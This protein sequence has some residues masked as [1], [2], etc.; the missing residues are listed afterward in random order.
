LCDNRFEWNQIAQEVDLVGSRR[1][2]I[3][4]PQRAQIALQC[5]ATKGKRD[6]TRKHLSTFQMI[7]LPCPDYLLRQPNVKLTMPLPEPCLISQEA[8]LSLHQDGCLSGEGN[9]AGD[10]F[11]AVRFEHTLCL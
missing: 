1:D 10:L 9:F 5:F 8:T 3:T 7:H 4:G 6:G 11:A 2:D